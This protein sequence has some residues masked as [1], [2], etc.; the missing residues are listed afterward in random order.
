MC[1]KVFRLLHWSRVQNRGSQVLWAKTWKDD[2]YKTAQNAWGSAVGP[3]M[4]IS[5]K[6][7]SQQLQTSSKTNVNEVQAGILSSPRR[8][9][10]P[11]RLWIVSEGVI[12]LGRGK[13]AR[14]ATL[15]ILLWAENPKK[16]GVIYADHRDCFVSVCEPEL[17]SV[18]FTTSLSRLVKHFTML[19]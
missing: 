16:Q 12:P 13:E 8:N 14:K 1:D 19:P 4:P 9:Q 3:R 7:Q 17:L 5:R 2:V 6:L 15:M 10:D 11:N 18:P